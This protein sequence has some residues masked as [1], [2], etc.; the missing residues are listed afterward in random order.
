MRQIQIDHDQS[1]L[2]DDLFDAEGPLPDFTF[3]EMSTLA[4]VPNWNALKGLPVCQRECNVAFTAAMKV[5]FKAENNLDRFDGVCQNYENGVAC[6]DS[7][8]DCPGR[9]TFDVLTSGLHFMCIEQ[10]KAFQRILNCID[11][12]RVQVQQHCEKVCRGR[13]RL[14][15]WATQ[16]GLLDIFGAYDKAAP[17]FDGEQFRAVMQDV[18]DLA[19]CYLTCVRTDYNN[20]CG[21]SA[22]TLISEAIVRPMAE[23]QS[24]PVIQH[25]SGFMNIFM[26]SQCGFFLNKDELAPHRIDPHLSEA[27]KRDAEQYSA[28]NGNENGLTGFEGTHDENAPYEGDDHNNHG[29]DP[30]QGQEKS[31]VQNVPSDLQNVPQSQNVP[32]PQKSAQNYQ[33]PAPNA[34]ANNSPSPSSQN[35]NLP[36]PN[37][38]ANSPRPNQQNHNLP[39]PSAQPQEHQFEFDKSDEEIEENLEGLKPIPPEKDGFQMPNDMYTGADGDDEYQEIPMLPED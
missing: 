26:P 15:N 29:F 18:C 2:D 12:E 31:V 38:Q 20:K 11:S 14:T 19:K 17:R 24:E 1:P 34:Q 6:Q 33:K 21:N 28:K 23:G 37:Q 8:V 39:R 27:L 9:D 3:E 30:R 16:S 32:N 22:G 10:K 7:L 36:R 4:V 5:A 13:V 35:S 25:M